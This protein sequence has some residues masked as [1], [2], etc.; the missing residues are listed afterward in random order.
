[1]RALRACCLKTISGSCRRASTPAAEDCERMTMTLMSRNTMRRVTFN[2]R[3]KHN[4]SLSI[5]DSIHL[6]DIILSGHFNSKQN[7][8]ISMLAR[9]AFRTAAQV[10]PKGSR[11][12]S[13][14]AGAGDYFARRD[15]IRAHAAGLQKYHLAGIRN[16]DLT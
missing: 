14:E 12:A 16:I 11:A 7:T 4:P 15:A 1:M 10:A 5:G 6:P 2:S 13:T 3:Y 8:M 9:T